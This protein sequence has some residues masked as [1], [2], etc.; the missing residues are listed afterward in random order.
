MSTW[1]PLLC[2]IQVFSTIFPSFQQ[3]YSQKPGA[4]YT[5]TSSSTN[6]TPIQKSASS[7]SFKKMLSNYDN[8]NYLHKQDHHHPHHQQQQYED[9]DDEEYYINDDDD[10]EPDPDYSTDSDFSDLDKEAGG[11]PPITNTRYNKAFLMRIEQSKKAAVTGSTGNVGGALTK[12]GLVACPNTPELRRRDMNVRGAGL[13]MRERASMPRDSSLNRMK[14]D[15]SNLNTQRRDKQQLQQQQQQQQSTVGGKVLPK[16]LDI[17]KY[18]SPAASNFL[19][20]DESKSTLVHRSPSSASV[21]LNRGD[22]ARTSV[23]SVKSAGSKPSSAKKD[24]S[25]EHWKR[26]S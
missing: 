17:S 4:K 22:N 11:K 13:S 25:G 14:Q 20:R 5:T 24:Q 15:I 19:K 7:T 9:E 1:F 6:K 3:Q 16:Y 12:Q 18:K 21:T 23:R 10:L 8:T 2:E 26:R